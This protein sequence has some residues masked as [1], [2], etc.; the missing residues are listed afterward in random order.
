MHPSVPDFRPN[1]KHEHARGALEAWSE[2]NWAKVDEAQRKVVEDFVRSKAPA[3]M[4]ATWHNQLSRGMVIGSDDP[5]FHLGVGMQVRNACR[6]KLPDAELPIV[7]LDHEGQLYGPSR[8]W[9]DY[10]FGVLAAIAA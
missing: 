4:L 6:A 3:N 7:F 8:N 5:R 2:A 1:A 9:D 10:Y